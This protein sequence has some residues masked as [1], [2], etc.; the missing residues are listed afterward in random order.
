MADKDSS[1]IKPV[2]SLQN[3]A[4]VTPTKRRG[5]RKRRQD[6]HKQNKEESEHEL[7]ESVDEKTI[8]NKLTEKEDDRNSDS[9]RID[10]CA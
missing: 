7:N 2:E 3:I 5:E 4:G 8:G 10:Y 6:L 1:I 9:T